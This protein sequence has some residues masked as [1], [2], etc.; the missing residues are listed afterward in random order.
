MYYLW[1]HEDKFQYI[2]LV[3]AWIRAYENSY[4]GGICKRSLADAATEYKA[5]MSGSRLTTSNI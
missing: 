5:D 1:I 2:N 3:G 4:N